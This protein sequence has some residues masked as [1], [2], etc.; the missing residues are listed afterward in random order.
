MAENGLEW[1]EMAGNFWIL[2]ELLKLAG[3]GLNLQKLAE[4]GWNS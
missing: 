1:L 3:T 2:M 4:N